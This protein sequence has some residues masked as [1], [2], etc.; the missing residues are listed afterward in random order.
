MY[1]YTR[2]EVADLLKISTRTVDRYVVS[3]KFRAKKE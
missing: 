1:K 2:Q 3:G